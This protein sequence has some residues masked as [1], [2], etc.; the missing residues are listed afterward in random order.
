[1]NGITK[2][3]KIESIPPKAIY[4]KKK[5]EK[6]TKVTHMMEDDRGEE[7]NS[8]KIIKS[9]LRDEWFWLYH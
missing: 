3:E 2:T 7:E 1:M 5:S 6:I 8:S 9:I 4:F